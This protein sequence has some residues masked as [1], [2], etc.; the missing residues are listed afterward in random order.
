M[1]TFYPRAD[2]LLLINTYC[3]LWQIGRRDVHQ[4][5]ERRLLAHLDGFRMADWM[6][7]VI[8]DRSEG[9]SAMPAS[10]WPLG[11]LSVLAL[12]QVFTRI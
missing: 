7:G 10:F 6:F 12:A 1:M 11:E 4:S 5:A 8:A 2:G 3:S 9:W